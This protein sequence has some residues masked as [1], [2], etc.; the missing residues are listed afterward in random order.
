MADLAAPPPTAEQLGWL[1]VAPPTDEH[2][3]P[4]AWTLADCSIDESKWTQP[5]VHDQ[6]TLERVQLTAVQW[7]GPVFRNSVLRD[8]VFTRSSFA[9]ARFENVTF[10]RCRFE[11]STFENCQFDHC[12]LIDCMMS[13]QIAVRTALRF[14]EITKLALTVIDMREC[15]LSGSTFVD[16]TLHCPR[17]SK[18]RADTLT[19][20]GGELRGADLTACE[21]RKLV[22]D[23]VAV[24]GLRIID[25]E[26]GEAELRAGRIDGLAISGTS[27]RR[28]VFGRCPELPGVRV[29]DCRI[30]ALELDSCPA[31]ASLLIADSKIDTLAVQ[32]SVLYDAAFERLEVGSGRFESSELTGVLFQDGAWKALELVDTALTDYVAVRGTRFD[33]L[34]FDR[35]KLDPSLDL[36]LDGD[37]YGDGSMTWGGVRGP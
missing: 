22:L 13:Y 9:H 36:R 34:R 7:Q 35:A 27:V 23:G 3:R 4:I 20:G 15:D 28:L 26:L 8:V 32:A 29:V 30:G 12:R 5:V 37:H 14:C 33:Q 19:I 6:L 24:E 10:E 31:I 11:R 17:I 21:L 1:S 16:S 25:G 2:D 18:T